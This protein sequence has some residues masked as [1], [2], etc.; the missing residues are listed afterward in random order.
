MNLVNTRFEKGMNEKMFIVS[1][2]SGVILNFD[3]IV[4]LYTGSDGT[5][6][7][8]KQTDGRMIILQDYE[9]KKEAKEAIAIISEEMSRK[10]IV[11][12]PSA[13]EIKGRI[14]NS[15]IMREQHHNIGGKKTKGHG[16]S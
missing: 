15:S 11:Y 4:E 2:E 5:A 8:A 1:K 7:V 14:V 10:D 13:K 3:N 9:V 12:V 6:V 16:G